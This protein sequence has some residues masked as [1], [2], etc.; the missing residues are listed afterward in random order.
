M[1]VATCAGCATFCC[2]GRLV[3]PQGVHPFLADDN[4]GHHPKEECALDDF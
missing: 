1:I 2:G 3:E 4:S